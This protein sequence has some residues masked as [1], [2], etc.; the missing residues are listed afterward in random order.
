MAEAWELA[1]GMLARAAGMAC[2][3]CLRPHPSV[4]ALLTTEDPRGFC[5]CDCC[6][7]TWASAVATLERERRAECEGRRHPGLRCNPKN[8][9]GPW[10]PMPLADLRSLVTRLE[11]ELGE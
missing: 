8:H 10:V 9:D 4:A 5:S 1:A 3:R 6:A 11:A 7:Q 2:P